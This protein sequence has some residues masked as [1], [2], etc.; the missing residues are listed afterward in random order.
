[1]STDERR[2]VQAFLKDLTDLCVKHSV[3]LSP[4]IA[5]ELWIEGNK[6]PTTFW[7]SRGWVLHASARATSLRNEDRGECIE[8]KHPVHGM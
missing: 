4:G 1:M 2:A 6:E 5:L 7:E 8:Y 3:H